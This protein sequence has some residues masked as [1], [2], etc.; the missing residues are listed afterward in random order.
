MRR[1]LYLQALPKYFE[2]VT[3]VGNSFLSDGS[4]DLQSGFLLTSK[5][6]I[7]NLPEFYL[8]HFGAYSYHSDASAA[9]PQN[10]C[11]D[12]TVMAPPSSFQ[13]PAAAGMNPTWNDALRT[14]TDGQPEKR[15]SR[16]FARFSV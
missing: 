8:D 9:Y 15:W 6:G 3:I 1:N 11:L 2:Q 4:A 10:S 14:C 5:D 16:T 13:H 7:N 12:Y